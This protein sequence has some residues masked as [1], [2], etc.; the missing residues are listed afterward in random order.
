MNADGW[1]VVG[2]RGFKA[3]YL[4]HPRALEEAVKHHGHVRAMA[5]I[6]DINSALEEM[7]QRGIREGMRLAQ[8]A[9]PDV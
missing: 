5:C 3:L 8:D 9:D 2:P 1:A 6:D 7:Y 4:E